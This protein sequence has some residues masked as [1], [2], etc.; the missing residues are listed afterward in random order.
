MSEQ[1][2]Q[3]VEKPTI[4]SLSAELG[5]FKENVDDKFNKIMDR[6]SPSAPPD[7]TPATIREGAPDKNRVQVP[8]KWV[9]L[10]ETILG[11]EFICEY[12][13]PPDGGQKFT[14]IVPLEKSN[15][16][17]EYIKEFKTDRRTK[18]LGN[19]GERGVKEWCL[20]VRTNLLRSE[21]K[22]PVYP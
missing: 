20:K 21:I 14:I 16:T 11:P 19:T 5:Q 1:E 4:K 13:L 7:S 2:V 3:V 17:K 9:E 6:L 15:A 10:V 18:E 12:E 22:L 8:P